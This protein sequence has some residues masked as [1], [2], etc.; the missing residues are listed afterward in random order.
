MKERLREFMV[1]ASL[2]AADLAD[3]IGVQRSNISHILNGR[4]NPGSQFIEKLLKSF[5][6]LD[7][8]WL[9]TGQGSMIKSAGVVKASPAERVLPEEQEGKSAEAGKPVKTKSLSTDNSL[10]IER[11]IVFYTNRSFREYNPQ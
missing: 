2:N 7:A 6:D 3:R 8:G 4:N 5:P 11:I 1:F 10:T 9:L